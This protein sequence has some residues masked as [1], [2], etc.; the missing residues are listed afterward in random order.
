M[1]D[2][3]IIGAGPAGLQAALFT[4][5]AGL[6]TLVAGDPT[7]SALADGAKIGN[8]FGILGEPSGHALLANSVAN[9]KTY[10]GKFATDEVVRLRKR[11]DGVFAGKTAT[12]MTIEAKTVVIATG[13]GFVSAG[14]EDERTWLGKGV[15]TCV[16]CDGYAY[17]GKSVA[18]VGEGNFA[19]EEALE[20]TA[21]TDKITIFSQGKAWTMSP[22]VR[23]ALADK[24]VS[25][26][27][28]RI[29]KLVAEQTVTGV[30]LEDGS[31]FPADGVFLALGTTSSVAF[32]QKLG[33]EQKDSFIAIDRD[34]TTNVDG[35]YAAGGCT[36]GNQQIAKS[37]GDGCNAAVAI[38]KKLRGVAQYS[39]QT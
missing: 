25:L 7:K 17:K 36:G 6:S 33:V 35:A 27:K 37:C 30:G 24:R 18:V 26:R 11:G 34:G 39:D 22:D 4:A 5:R 16:A 10:G 13:A 8:A 38:I 31:G 2:V 19:A 23:N 9:V 14:I 3:L 20:L 29:V 15:H 1:Y 32:A 21:Y 12:G 28:D